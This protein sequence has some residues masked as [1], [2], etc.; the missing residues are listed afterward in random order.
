MKTVPDAM[1]ST[2]ML[3]N[4]ANMA[5]REL[6]SPMLSLHPFQTPAEHFVDH[7]LIPSATRYGMDICTWPKLL[8][9]ACNPKWN[10][11]H[12]PP[13]IQ[14]FLGKCLA[15]LLLLLGGIALQESVQG[16][17]NRLRI[18]CLSV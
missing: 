4:L 5:T 18:G 3:A 14:T 11:L 6:D 2:A 15:F 10:I 8:V 17:V 12:G 13:S 7:Q 9:D 1:T 16:I